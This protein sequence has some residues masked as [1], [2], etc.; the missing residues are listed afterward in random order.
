MN[1][2]PETLFQKLFTYLPIAKPF[3][4][5]IIKCL[6][7]RGALL[8]MPSEYISFILAT[9]TVVI[10]VVLY[11]RWRES[12]SRFLFVCLLFLGGWNLLYAVFG[13]TCS[14]M[15]G[16]FKVC[17]AELKMSY[18]LCASF[19]PFVL[20]LYLLCRYARGY[21]EK[22]ISL[23]HYALF[24]AWFWMMR[25]L[26]FWINNPLA[27]IVY[28]RKSETATFEIVALGTDYR[29]TALLF[30]LGPLVI[31]RILYKEVYRKVQLRSSVIAIHYIRLVEFTLS[32]LGIWT[33][34]NVYLY[35]HSII[36]TVP[37]CTKYIV[38][39]LPYIFYSIF[40]IWF[41]YVLRQTNKI[42]HERI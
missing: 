38:I 13:I 7:D 10:L 40:S 20:V 2:Y 34:A 3:G 25:C 36:D 18:F 37:L 19:V 24:F 5:D 17:G 26:V 30:I 42:G 22:R 32:F 15:L 21:D 33:A 31:A 8:Y 29:F 41:M 1:I 9:I 4:R 11:M 35:M 28:D 16:T 12:I 39:L 6:R 14:L 27:R 23:M